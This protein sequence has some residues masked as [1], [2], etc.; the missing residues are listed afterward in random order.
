MD[1]QIRV[2]IGAQYQWSERVRVG[3]AIEYI[4]LGDAKIND[5]TFLKGKY[6]KNR[7]FMVA[8]N[9]GYQF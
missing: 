8:V 6:D 3:G 5:S 4:D 9:L 1:R 7:I 2:A